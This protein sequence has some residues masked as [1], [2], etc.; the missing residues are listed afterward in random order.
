MT[1]LPSPSWPVVRRFDAD[2]LHRVCLPVGGIGT[3]TIGFGGRG[4]LRDVEIANRPAKGFVPDI[5]SLFVRVA[6]NAMT[7]AL[8]VLE[9][10]LDL[11]DYEGSS[12]SPAHNHGLPRFRAAEYLTAY[13]FGRVHL[14]DPR[15]PV[16]AAVEAWN[17]FIPVDVDS[18]S[19]PLA[20]FDV[21]LANV[22]DADLS[23]SVVFNLRNTL[24]AM[25]LRA[26]APV[27]RNRLIE[28][29]GFTGVQLLPGASGLPED[30]GD[31]AIA[32]VHGEDVS[33]RTN[34]AELTWGGSPLDFAD[35]LLQDGA[36]DERPVGVRRPV[37]S[38]CERRSLAPGEATTIRLLMSWRF[39]D[40]GSWS[41]AEP[42][43][44]NHYATVFDDSVSVLSDAAPRLDGLRSATEEF[45]KAYWQSDLPAVVK[46]AAL[47]NV[48]TLRTQ[49]CFRTADG[50]FF[51]W[52]GCNDSVG[53][54]PGSCTHVWNYE[55]ATPFLFGDLARSMREVELEQAT[56]DSGFMSFRVGL[57]L[58]D[59]AQDWQVAAADGQMGCIVKLYREW[60]LSGDDSF[61]RRHWPRARA[62]L[63]F[64]WVPG[65]W[66]ADVDGVMEGVQHNTMDVEYHGPNPQMEVW[67]LAALRSAAAMA[68]YVGDESFA[69][70]CA[71]LADRGRDWTEANLFNGD[72]YEHKVQT[73]DHAAPGL[74]I[75][76]LTP[77]LQ[78][79]AGCL[80]DQLVGQFL[81]HVAGLGHL[82][83]KEQMTTA[84]RSVV[85]FNR[86]EG[87]FD[88]NNVMR[89]Y[90]LGDETAVLM[91]SY[92]HGDRPKE[93]FS[94][95]TE[96]MTGF[97]YTLA[98]GLAYE[99]AVDEALRVVADVRE[100]YDGRRRN[101][102]DE[103][104]C[105]HHYA[106]AMASWGVLLAL[107][108]FHYDGVDHAMTIASGTHFF[109]TGDAWGTVTTEAGESTVHVLGGELRLSALE[110]PGLGSA[111][112]DSKVLTKGDV[113]QL[114]LT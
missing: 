14:T 58:A 8:K 51:G 82:L 65:G 26:D 30:T 49:T 36:L 11:S 42:T 47:A 86:R 18:S 19:L 57:P 35:D 55:Q 59:K 37:A 12:G 84:L 97:E 87:F 66:D 25:R 21:T 109:S 24:G 33:R 81:A 54:C 15:F 50:R 70:K 73:S 98:A 1:S 77:A 56:T 29:P 16:E 74:A 100:R 80:I 92:P 64:C 9:G 93:P 45:V 112:L 34:W 3:G 2:H 83:D 52:E 110:I 61:L 20:V 4:D 96:V 85:R 106:R 99:G 43:V 39:P 31:I 76:G 72:Y 7:P 63:E 90:V 28:G 17:P 60:R 27:G 107:S 53:C 22:S 67:Y 44:T 40:R 108:G 88:H 78:L 91:A 105:G 75:S 113:V 48:S 114:T 38:V 101:P 6:G 94:Y 104:E 103:A 10:P 62:A 46:E 5:A 32:V 111:T 95:F 79:G 41:D 23:V 69:V 89:S 71:D 102:Y 13:P 68:S